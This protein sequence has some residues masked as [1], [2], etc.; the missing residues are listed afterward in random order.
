MSETTPETTYKVV[1]IGNS[2]VGKSNIVSRF[3]AD[4]FSH[5]SKATIGVEFGHAEVEIG[6]DRINVQLWDTAGQERFKAMTGGYYRDSVGALLVYDIT[7]AV[8]FEATSKWLQEL[9]NYTKPETVIMLTGNKCDLTNMREVATNEAKAFAQ[10]EGLLFF[11][12]S[13]LDGENIR[14]AFQALIEDIYDRVHKEKPLVQDKT[15]RSGPDPN[16]DRTI[17]R[18]SADDPPVD[19]KT[20]PGDGG[21]C[22]C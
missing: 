19:T 21:G 8:S 7:K 4:E 11:E 1:V 12:T 3:T 15:D 16:K 20:K 22:A 14:E 6:N 9:R 5:E 18:P 10:K 2:N 17:I 13:A